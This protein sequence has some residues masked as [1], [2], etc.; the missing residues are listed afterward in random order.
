M[1]TL[2]G[3][4]VAHEI[5]VLAD[6]MGL[7][8]SP[9]YR[10]GTVWF[11]DWLAGDILQHDVATGE[12]TLTA[13]IESLPLC[14]DLGPEGEILALDSRLRRV[15][16]VSGEQRTVADLSALP[17]RGGNEVLTAPGRMYINLGNFD[18]AVGFP[19][20]PVGLVATIDP[21]GSSRIVA[22]TIDFP[23]GM[24]LTL[25]GSELIVAESFA[26][27]LTAFTIEP[28]GS[29]T[30]RRV[31]ADLD[32]GAPDGISMAPDGTCWYAEVPGCQVVRVAEGGAVLDRV[33]LD[34]GA[35]SCV[36]APDL[37]TLFVTAAH[38]P[39]GERMFDPT[40]TWDGQLLAVSLS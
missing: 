3:S 39:G 28:D 31:W 40:H 21:D 37:D 12:T 18:P 32:G 16:S 22:D 27:V 30:N 34:R 4:R 10:S 26:G 1:S 29:L 36:L 35:F 13:R 9:R 5:T 11:S 33:Q 23:N 8:E 2:G 25:D 7:V 15:V 14:F 19:T 6:G 20:S 17:G 38:W 24:A